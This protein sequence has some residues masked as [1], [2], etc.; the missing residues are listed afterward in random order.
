MINENPSINFTFMKLEAVA[1]KVGMGKSTLLAWESSGKFPRAVR[2]SPTIRVWLQQDIDNWI[3]EQH[4]K[5]LTNN[6]GGRP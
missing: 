4:G 6:V 1:H 5:S 2:L 3:L